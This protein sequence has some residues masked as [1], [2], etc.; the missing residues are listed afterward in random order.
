MASNS[1]NHEHWTRFWE[2]G[3]ITTFGPST[4]NNYEISVKAFWYEQFDKL[5]PEAVILDVAAGNGAIAVIA[6]VYSEEH[7]KNFR[8]RAADAAIIN[9]NLEEASQSY[10]K[11]RENIDFLSNAPCENLPFKDN[12]IDLVCSQFGIEYSV[13][14]ESLQEVS[15]VLKPGGLFS[16]IMHHTESSIISNVRAERAV[17]IEA[18]D[19]RHVFKK[20]EHCFSVIGQ[21]SDPS[22]LKTLRQT[23]LVK[24]SATELGNSLTEL[25]K[26]HPHS[27]IA[28][29]I[30]TEINNIFG[31]NVA[32]SDEERQLAIKAVLD[33]LSLQMQREKDLESA[34][35]SPLM[36]DLL[37]ET[38][39]NSGLAEF[40]AEVIKS[41]DGKISG[42]KVEARKPPSRQDSNP[43]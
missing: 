14:A 26:K 4:P 6:A 35:I 43:D 39:E 3:Y 9:D 13:L 1:N 25:L 10:N 2:R 19:E 17:L 34:A 7:G 5:S 11:Y 27:Q 31:I 16:A 37:K 40:H 15:R 33:D 20:L 22:V 23:P 36:M 38:A 21:V 18:I 28:K 8:I 30:K 12:S 32:K 29:R 42:W 41:S 24:Q